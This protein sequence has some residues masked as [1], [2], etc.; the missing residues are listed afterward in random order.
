MRGV[1]RVSEH[2][3]PETHGFGANLIFDAEGLSPYWG[4]V[5]AFDPDHEETLGSFDA[6]GDRWTI[7]SSTYWE[8]KIAPPEGANAEG[9]LYE[10]SYS[11]EADDGIGDRDANIQFRPGCPGAEHVDSGESIQGLPDDCPESIRVQVET[12]NV[13]H[14][15][16]LALVRALAEHI[17]LNPDYFR[18]PHEWSRAY[19]IERY[20]RLLRQVYEDH[21]VDGGVLGQLADVCSNQRGKGKHRWDNEEI[22]GHYESVAETA[23]TW[24][25][26]LPD[27]VASTLGKSV[28]GYHPA[29]PRGD[30][31]GD[32]PL[33]HPKLEAARAAEFDEGNG[34]PWD[35]VDEAL[36]ELD[37]TLLNVLSWAGVPVAA[38]AAV[39]VRYDDYFDVDARSGTASLRSNPLP[40]LRETII[41]HAE[42]EMIRTE[43]SP[44]QEEALT[45]LTD[46]GSMHYESLAD[47][48]DVGT[49]TVYR[50]VENLRSL[51]ETDNGLV[52]FADDVTRRH[53]RGIVDR[54][55]ETA[56][57]ARES[58]QQIAQEHD[59][60]RSDDGP[61]QEWMQRHGV[62][63]VRQHPELE[64][65]IDQ[66]V[67]DVEIKQILRAGLE[68][69]ERSS[70]LT[71]RFEDALVTWHDLDGTE[72]PGRQ[73]VVGGDVLGRG[74]LRSL[75]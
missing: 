13:D 31:S 12:T 69:A 4:V 37:A 19:Q 46:G 65:E 32:D 39:W 20:V 24:S 7:E 42:S 63:L 47:Q 35:Q 44:A 17:G 5:S 54:V 28:K 10:Y 60:L 61:L 59:L 36:D 62:R 30:T 18:D 14:D 52:R 73:I 43:L 70:L 56:D 25:M 3:R 29:N 49:S 55:R 48:A 1:V 66:P 6:L 33:A 75:L 53:V 51:L 72:H 38:D 57:W 34:V 16:V 26:L 71:N 27:A 58:I 15:D 68:A 67:G 8:G 2:V 40:D 21:I 74:A 64:F 22:I 50:L 45:V 23:E 9:G 11:I 41:E